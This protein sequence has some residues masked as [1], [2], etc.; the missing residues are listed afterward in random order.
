MGVNIP[1]GELQVTCGTTTQQAVAANPTRRYLLLVNDSDNA[2]YISL[3]KEAVIN[4][5][6]RLNSA[7][8]SYEI[9]STNLWLG[10]IS[11]VSSVASKILTV[12]EW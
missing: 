10:N 4:H 12:V 8:G 3:G 7:G 1:T 9:N 5:G 2:I 6:I 11:A